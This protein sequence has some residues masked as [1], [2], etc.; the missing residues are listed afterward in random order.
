MFG[1]VNDLY[2]HLDKQL[3]ENHYPIT[4]NDWSAPFRPKSLHYRGD[5][6][7]GN[8]CKTLLFNTTDAAKSLGAVV[9]DI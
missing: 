9:I 7:N 4:T 1:V 8:Q 6:F 3:E 2:V 5:Q